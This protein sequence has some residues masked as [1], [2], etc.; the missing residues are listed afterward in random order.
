VLRKLL[1]NRKGTAEIIG[2]VLFIVILLFFFTNV[3]L[4]HDAATKE[5]DELYVQKMNSGMGIGLETGGSLNITASGGLDVVLSRLW[6]VENGA[7]GNHFYAN[8]TSLS[9]DPNVS[10]VRVLAGHSITIQF[11]S[12]TTLTAPP[13]PTE[14]NSVK[15]ELNGNDIIIYYEQPPTVSSV[16]FTIV[17]S[18]GVTDSINS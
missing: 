5:M 13:N 4:W 6:I 7:T 2:S 8:L 17:N 1:S 11:V 15:A 12:P 9:T 3:Y 10:G 18:L 14:P 16:K